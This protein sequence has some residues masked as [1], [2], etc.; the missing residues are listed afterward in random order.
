MAATYAAPT[1]ANLTTQF[2]IW[3]PHT[4]IAAG[5]D[6]EQLNLALVTLEG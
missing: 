1:P 4:P 3:K 5:R 2:I 6:P